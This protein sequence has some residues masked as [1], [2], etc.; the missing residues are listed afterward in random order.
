MTYSQQN[1]PQF[2]L[3]MTVDMTAAIHFRKKVKSEGKRIGFN[4]MII[5]AVAMGIAE[6]R[7]YTGFFDADGVVLRDSIDIGFAVSLEGGLIVP[8]IRAA[9]KLGLVE[10]ASVAKDLV[11]KA[12]SN[13]LLPEECQGS[14]FSVSNLGM[15]RVEHFTAIVPP[16]ESGILAVGRIDRKPYVVGRSIE[17]RPTVNYTLTSDHRVVDGVAA[18]KLCEAIRLRLEEP[19]RLM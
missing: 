19:E 9:D 2:Y 8:V 6:H 3:T 5:K 10:M 17:I 13:R 4:D 12:R 16:G 1:I 14:V 7:G 11:E 15:Y 18:A